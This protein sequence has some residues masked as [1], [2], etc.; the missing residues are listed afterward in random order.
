MLGLIRRL[1][2]P[3]YLNEFC[4]RHMT[5]DRGIRGSWL[6]NPG[7]SQGR[8]DRGRCLARGSDQMLVAYAVLALD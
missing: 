5:K 2:V 1:R 4:F 7:A 3:F 6:L 8:P